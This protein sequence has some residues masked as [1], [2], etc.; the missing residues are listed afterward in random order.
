MIRTIAMPAD[1][2]P[3]DDIFGGWTILA[4][5]AAGLCASPLLGARTPR[6]VPPSIR[7]TH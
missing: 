5:P 6:V 4:G 1:T 3:A 2:R 7:D